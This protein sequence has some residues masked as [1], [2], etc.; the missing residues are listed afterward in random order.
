MPASEHR[1]ILS[2]R[3]RRIAPKAA[4]RLPDLSKKERDAL[5]DQ[6]EEFEGPDRREKRGTS[7]KSPREPGVSPS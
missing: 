4:R 6:V 1:I 7:R 3:P 2:E 5:V